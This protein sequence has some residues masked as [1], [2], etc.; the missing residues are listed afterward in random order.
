LEVRKTKKP[1]GRQRPATTRTARAVDEPATDRLVG[2]LLEP[3]MGVIGGADEDDQG[4]VGE[5][6]AR[7]GIPPAG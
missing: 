3:P 5:Q 1:T 6:Q 4:H 7:A 2:G